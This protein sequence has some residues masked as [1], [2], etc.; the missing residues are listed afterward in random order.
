ML[1][2]AIRLLDP[3]IACSVRIYGDETFYPEYVAQ[4]RAAA[5]GDARVRFAGTFT[6]NELPRVIDDVDV[7]IVPSTWSENTP[8]VIFAAQ[9]AGRPVIGSN[10]S[11][12][13]ALIE[14]GVN[15]RLFEAGSATALAAV[16]EDVL[17]RPE[18]LLAMSRKAIQAKDISHYVADLLG[19]YED[20][21]AERAVDVRAQKRLPA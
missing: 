10:V 21:L 12:I 19:I 14:D 11:G 16:L 20:V 9:A 6:R 1:V 3:G 18:A 13:A 15:G 8:L 2:D 4:I 5:E 17:E 7:L